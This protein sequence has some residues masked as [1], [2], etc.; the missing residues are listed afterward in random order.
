MI[1]SRNANLSLG[2]FT[3]ALRKAFSVRRIQASKFFGSQGGSSGFLLC[4]VWFALMASDFSSSEV[5]AERELAKERACWRICSAYSRI[6]SIVAFSPGGSGGGDILAVDVVDGTGAD[7]KLKSSAPCCAG[8]VRGRGEGDRVK[9]DLERVATSR[10]PF[11]VVIMRRGGW[12]VSS[13]SC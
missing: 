2:S 4:V 3:P 11:G 6:S 10:G 7:S 1:D 8:G 12:Q 13:S 9:P 5:V